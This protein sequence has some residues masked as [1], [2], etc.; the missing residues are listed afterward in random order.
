M[1]KVS[2][3]EP[4]AF[5][6]ERGGQV[7][8][9]NLGNGILRP[10]TFDPGAANEPQTR[11]DRLGRP[12]TAAASRG[13]IVQIC[14]LGNHA[15]LRRLLGGGRSPSKPVSVAG[16]PANREKNREFAKNL[17]LASDFISNCQLRSMAYEKIP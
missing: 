14:G 16:F 3:F 9:S 10:E 6:I 5:E 7:A 8:N 11:W 4:E 12:T 1:L 13:N 2:R 15:D 17:H